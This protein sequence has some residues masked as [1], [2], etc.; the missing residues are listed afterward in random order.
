MT[1]WQKISDSLGALAIISALVYSSSL[2][3]LPKLPTIP[4]I[5]VELLLLVVCEFGPFSSFIS[6]KL[7]HSLSGLMMLHLDQADWLA[8]YFVYSVVVSSLAMVWDLIGIFNSKCSFRFRYSS[9]RDVGIS[10]YLVIVMI[11]FLQ[12]IPLEIIKPVFFADPLGAVVG[13]GLT[14]LGVFNPKWI[15]E[16]TVG[17]SSAVFLSTL[18]TL[19]HG[20]WLEKLLISLIVTIVEGLSKQYDNL[21]ITFVVL[22]AY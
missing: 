10:V 7:V 13:R 4:L 15:G 1:T 16:K 14:M 5:A 22:T 21:F 2:T 3:L 11:F 9:A 17:G 12:R 6:R 19:I 8:R 20:R 18:L